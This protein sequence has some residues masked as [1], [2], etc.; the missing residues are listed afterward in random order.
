MTT[1][2]NWTRDQPANAERSSR[3]KA[4][5]GVSLRYLTTFYPDR[6]GKDI[7]SGD[8]LRIG[9]DTLAEVESVGKNGRVLLRCSGAYAWVYP[10]MIDPLA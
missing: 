4:G 7:L 9:S 1:R 10:D 3:F 5:D 6:G 8:P 2:R